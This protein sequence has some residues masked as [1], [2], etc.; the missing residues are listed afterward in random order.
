[1]IKK[2]KN[3]YYDSIVTFADSYKTSFN[4]KKQKTKSVWQ[5]MDNNII[6]YYERII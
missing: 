6:N 2:T 4:V 1:M 3:Y 5:S